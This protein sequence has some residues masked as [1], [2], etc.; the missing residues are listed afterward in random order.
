M[1][2]IASFAWKWFMQQQFWDFPSFRWLWQ[3]DVFFTTGS[4][5]AFSVLIFFFPDPQFLSLRGKYVKSQAD[6]YKKPLIHQNVWW[7]DRRNP[8]TQLLLLM[9]SWDHQ[10]FP[11]WW[12]QCYSGKIFLQATET[13]KICFGES[14]S[15]GQRWLWHTPVH[16]S[17]AGIWYHVI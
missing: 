4:R 14:R 7:E 6:H 12:P 16:L 13:L 1:S 2:L 17:S 8:M 10:M 9:W 15:E 3:G 11:E 5:A